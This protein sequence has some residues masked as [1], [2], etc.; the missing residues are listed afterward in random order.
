MGHLSV[1]TF[2]NFKIDM[3]QAKQLPLEFLKVARQLSGGLMKFSTP[4]A[5]LSLVTSVAAAEVPK[6][7]AGLFQKDVPV[8]GQIG[9][10]MPPEEINKY[11]AKVQDS[12][13][14][15]TK[16]FKEF[17]ATAKPGE[18]LPYDERLGLTKAEYD[19]YLALWKKREFKPVAEVMLNLRQS[20]GDTW[21]LTATGEAS[22]FSTLRYSPK[23]DTFISPN[24]KMTRLED[25]KADASSLL[26]QWTGMEWKF[27]EETGLGKTKENFALGR[28]ADNKF[29]LVVYRAQELSTEGTRLLDK[30][31]V[32]RFPLGKA[33]T[34]EKQTKPV[35]KKK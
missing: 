27:E 17:S 23:T 11:I 3:G 10:V 15:D 26:G 34:P 30:S 29:G 16:W 20:P 18:P 22:S 33:T 25:I 24:G 32:V 2:H 1:S 14:K 28:F 12:A 4:L 7:F 31:L 5:V 21:T 9:V 13:R 35:P 19:E 8:Q 6:I